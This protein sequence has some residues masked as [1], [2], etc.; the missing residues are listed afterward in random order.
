LSGTL[1]PEIAH[2]KALG[3]RLA[4]RV[5]RHRAAP[6]RSRDPAWRVADRMVEVSSFGTRGNA[7]MSFGRVDRA[8]E[9]GDGFVRFR[10][11]EIKKQEADGGGARL[12]IETGDD[13]PI[14][15]T[16]P[17]VAIPSPFP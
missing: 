2:P 5:R 3:I 12:I 7:R 6:G 4:F 1:H 8:V 11:G 14:G 9:E 17:G 16:D 10:W 13:F 15:P